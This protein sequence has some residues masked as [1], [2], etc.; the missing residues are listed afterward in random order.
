M[1]GIQVPNPTDLDMGLNFARVISAAGQT[2]KAFALLDQMV[3]GKDINADALQ[4]IA[5][6][7]QT[8]SVGKLGAAL[9]RWTEV[10]PESPEV[11]NDFATLKAILGKN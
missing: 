5:G 11:W 4:D 6:Y 1:E 2:N 9:A 10:T 8:G 3:A 7:V